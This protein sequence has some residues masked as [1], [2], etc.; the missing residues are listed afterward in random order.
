LDI[1][2]AET[3]IPCLSAVPLID[4]KPSEIEFGVVTVENPKL[5]SLTEE[6]IDV[7]LVTLA[8]RD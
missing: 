6:D 1:W 4:F 3:A 2:T 7:H 5:R 8:K